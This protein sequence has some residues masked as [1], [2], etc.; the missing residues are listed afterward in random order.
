MA[1]LWQYTRINRLEV[2]LGKADIALQYL[3]SSIPKTEDS[4]KEEGV[5]RGV[6]KDFASVN[7]S[8]N[9]IRFENRNRLRR[10]AITV[11]H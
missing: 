8:M 11:S 4:K 1:W 9:P 6:Q 10:E 2:F 3:E 7:I 5:L